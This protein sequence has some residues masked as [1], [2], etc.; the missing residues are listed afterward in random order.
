MLALSHSPVRQ[1]EDSAHKKKH[2]RF[3][4]PALPG[5]SIIMLETSRKYHIT[6]EKHIHALEVS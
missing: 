2:F 6:Y 1:V 4:S 5:H 3:N